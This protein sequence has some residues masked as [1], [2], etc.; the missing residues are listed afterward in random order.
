MLNSNSQKRICLEESWEQ[1]QH[2]L[3]KLWQLLAW[4]QVENGLVPSSRRPRDCHSH[5]L[6]PCPLW[7]QC[8][9]SHMS[10]CWT[11]SCRCTHRPAHQQQLGWGTAHL[12]IIR[13]LDVCVGI[14][15]TNLSSTTSAAASTP[16]PCLSS[17]VCLGVRIVSG[18][19]MSQCVGGSNLVFPLLSSLHL[20]KYSIPRCSQLEVWMNQQGSGKQ[21][22]ESSHNWEAPLFSLGSLLSSDPEPE[23]WVTTLQHSR[24]FWNQHNNS[25]IIL[26]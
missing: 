22:I 25:M 9:C 16:A 23:Q 7:R 12:R 17:T 24:K 13:S 8:L 15:T 4:L 11:A 3:F 2:S 1:P 10:P 5:L 6:H 26:W 21:K 20:W 14:Y 18:Q 19:N